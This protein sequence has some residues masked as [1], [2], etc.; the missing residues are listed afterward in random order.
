VGSVSYATTSDRR[1]KENIVDTHFSID[2]LMKIQVRDFNFKKDANKKIVAGFIAQELAPIVPDAVTVPAKTEE[3]W[4]VDYGRLTPI[5][6][7]A[8]QDQ[9]KTIEGLESDNAKLKAENTEMKARLEKIEA[10]LGL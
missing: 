7:K 5:L 2:D 1:L 9:Q 6:V 8:V 3:Y 4:S 10:R